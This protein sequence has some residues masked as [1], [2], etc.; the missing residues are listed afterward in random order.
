M[1]ALVIGG[2]VSGLTSALCLLRAGHGATIWAKALPPDTTSNVAAAVWYPYKAYPEDRVT[3]WGAEAYRAFKRLAGD[4]ATGVLMAQ[5]VEARPEPASDPW[6]VSAVEGFRHARPEE[7]PAGYADGYVF[8]APVIA[9]PIYLSYLLD[10]VRTEGGI[11]EQRDV[12]ELG[13]ALARSVVVVNCAGLGARELASDSDL[14]AARGQVVRVRHNGYRR[15]LLDDTGPNAVAYIVPRVDDIVLG[16]VDDEY[17]E[18]TEVDPA[19]IPDILR[20]CAN[21]APEF[22]GITENDILGVAVGLRPVRSAVRLEAER[23]GPG[24]AVIHNYG[25]GGAGVTLSWGCAAEVVRLVASI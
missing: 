10:R 21:L 3:A 19:Q 6:W 18:R 4:A 17:D 20:R 13:E 15:V 25:H 24:Q 11:V 1:E 12:A 8:D 14:H 16:G 5:V 9:M 7:L 23:P 2:G 22:A